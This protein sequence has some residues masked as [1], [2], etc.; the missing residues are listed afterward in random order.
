MKDLM[1]MNIYQKTIL[2][3]L[4]KTDDLKIVIP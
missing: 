3:L 2:N 1:K 4:L